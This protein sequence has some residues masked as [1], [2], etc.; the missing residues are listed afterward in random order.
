MTRLKRRV[1]KT[2]ECVCDDKC[3]ARF[4]IGKARD[5]ERSE[6]RYMQ[7]GAAAAAASCRGGEEKRGVEVKGEEAVNSQFG[8]RCHCFSVPNDALSHKEAEMKMI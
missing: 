6:G 3:E 7:F 4:P 8:A 5:S 1:T 2:R